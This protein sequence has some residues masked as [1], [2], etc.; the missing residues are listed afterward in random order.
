MKAV[1]YH[2][3]RR[4]TTDLPH[5]R[6]LHV[7]DFVAQLDYFAG[8]IGLVTR[9]ALECWLDG[10]S[11][12]T[13]ALLTFDD[14]LADHAE[15]VWPILAERN[16]FGIFYVATG[17]YEAGRLLDVHRV[18]L[19][20]G[21]HGGAAVAEQLA[22]IVRDEWLIDSQVMAF[23]EDTYK[24]QRDNT[25]AVNHVKRTLNYYIDYAHRQA[26][27]DA[28]MAHFFGAD[29]GSLADGFYCRPEQLKAMA[30]GGQMIGGHGAKH[31]V[32]SKLDKTAQ[33]N[34][35]TACLDFLSK[36]IEESVTT[37]C[38]PYG[39]F[40]T[41]TETTERLLTEQGCRFSFNVEPRD[42]EEADIRTRPQAL[43]RYDC[44][45]FPHGRTSYGSQRAAQ[46]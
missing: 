44:N 35:I 7:D 3:V 15:I 33:L 9:E 37:F 23:R 39:G 10:G 38:Y 32:F 29:E 1:M 8:T 21:S 20:T 45:M 4:P 34:E 5:F 40:H 12:P 26:A 2:Y 24:Y 36:T 31:L 41:F 17:P 13:G 27:I 6:Y 22:K 18:H 25:E 30:E 43:P 19:L 14:G 16:L 46:D 11:R 42:V 28:L